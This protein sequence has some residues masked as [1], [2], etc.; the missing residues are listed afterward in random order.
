MYPTGLII[1][2][3]NT[4]ASIPAAWERATDYDGR[5]LKG[6]ADAVDPGSNGGNATHTHTSS[7]HTHALNSHTHTFSLGAWSSHDNSSSNK[8]SIPDEANKS[9]H[10]G[11]IHSGTSN[12]QSG[13]TTQSS[14]VTYGSV[15]N[16]P[17]YY[18]LIL[19]RALQYNLL[20][21]SGVVFSKETSRSGLS[22]LS[23]AASRFLRIAGTGADAGGTGGSSTN[24]H[25]ISHTHS[26]NTHT[27]TATSGVSSYLDR[28]GYGG[29]GNRI[30]SHT[31]TF[32]TDAGTTPID[33]YSDS[34]TTAETV[35]PAYTTLNPF[36]NASGVNVLP[37]IGDIAM[38][39]GLLAD[40]PP[41]LDLCDGSNGTVDMRERFFKV[42]ASAA[43][44]TTGGS[45]THTH[46]SQSHSHTSSAHNHTKSNLSDY[47][48]TYSADNTGEGG[49]LTGGSHA[50]TIDNTSATYASATTAADSSDNQPLNRTVVF[51]QLNAAALT[52]GAIL[53][54]L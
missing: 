31:H 18:D 36:K 42:P 22:F 21:P 19:I 43:S 1:G 6:W 3:D 44:S 7:G 35:E 23:A 38:W 41:G 30:G 49:D 14:S 4:H 16:N 15:S 13:G 45:N 11:H 51:V 2:Y 25:D 5:F 26:T 27:H 47:G 20:P 54:L 40:L 17:P 29:S 9:V 37:K 12:T 39:D 52:N 10:D 46:A 53:M 50:V 32:T 28:H 34:L 8:T 48:A 24:V 33:S